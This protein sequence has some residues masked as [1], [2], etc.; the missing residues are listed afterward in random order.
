MKKHFFILILL[1]LFAANTSAANENNSVLHG[2]NNL[3][4][5]FQSSVSDNNVVCNG[6]LEVSGELSRTGRAIIHK[7]QREFW[8]S[9]VTQWGIT[10]FSNLVPITRFAT[11]LASGARIVLGTVA[12]KEGATLVDDVAR[13]AEELFKTPF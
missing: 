6:V 1:F 12:V 7:G 13:H 9:P 4:L 2:V 8:E 11:W 3:E 10:I 5:K